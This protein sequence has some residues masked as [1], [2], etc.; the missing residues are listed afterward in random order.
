MPSSRPRAGARRA[1]FCSCSALSPCP[2]GR[3]PSW[4]RPRPGDGARLERPAD[5]ARLRVQRAGG[6]GRGAAPR[7]PRAARCPGVT[8]RA[9]P[10]RRC[11]VRPPGRS[12][13]GA[14]LLSYRVTSV[15]GHPVGATLR[16]GAGGDATAASASREA[17]HGGPGRL[18]GAWR[19][20]T[21]RHCGAVGLTL[22]TAAGAPAEPRVAGR[23]WR[24]ARTG[25]LAGIASSALRLGMAGIEL[26]GLPPGRPGVD[27]RAVADGG[28]DERSAAPRP[29]P[30]RRCSPCWW[31]GRTGWARRPP[32]P[33]GGPV[34]RADGP[35][36]DG[37]AALA[38]WRRH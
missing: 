31:R 24:W 17:I 12:P 29:W 26:R 32:G 34:V 18:H 13:Q 28:G 23:A 19:W 3:T 14:W 9:A 33:A 2:P 6:A 27:R 20:S 7:C 21:S 11:V 36:G 35:C 15:D 10:A 1:A 5:R 16:F 25:L 30:C 22:F 37:R 4:W 38:E 8:V